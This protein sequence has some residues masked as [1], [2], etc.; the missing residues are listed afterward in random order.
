MEHHKIPVRVLKCEPPILSRGN[1]CR[2]DRPSAF[3]KATPLARQNISP[4]KLPEFPEIYQSLN[5]I[6]NGW[7]GHFV[8]NKSSFMNL[9][10]NIFELN[11]S[12]NELVRYLHDSFKPSLVPILLDHQALKNLENTCKFLKEPI[13]NKNSPNDRKLTEKVLD[14][15]QDSKSDTT[16]NPEESQ[17]HTQVFTLTRHRVGFYTKQERLQKIKKYKAKILAHTENKNKIR[18]MLKSRIASS[19]PRV[20]GRFVK[21]SIT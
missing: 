11:F 17:T 18:Y 6:H 13:I 12:I 9:P 20:G 2:S 21:K 4:V 10:Q 7:N 16:A 5:P 8:T 15:D 3:S 19:K 14:S 1:L